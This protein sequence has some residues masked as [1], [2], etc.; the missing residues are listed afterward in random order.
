MAFVAVE[1]LLGGLAS[2]AGV[3]VR[4]VAV[5]IVIVVI[6]VPVYLLQAKEVYLGGHVGGIDDV[7]AV[8]DQALSPGLLY[9]LVEELLEALGP[10]TLAKTAEGGVIGR[11]F[12]GA[13]AQEALEHQIPGG[14]FLQL[15]I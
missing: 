9:Y 11:Q 15:S 3:G 2:E 10:Q 13:Q 7:Q 6:P 1:A 14:S 4:G 5:H 12:L 8:R